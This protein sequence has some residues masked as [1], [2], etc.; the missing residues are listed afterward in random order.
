MAHIW[1]EH[2]ETGN[3]AELPDL[4]YWRAR[5]WA[6]TD[7]PPPEPDLT[8]DPLPHAEPVEELTEPPEPPGVS[9]VQPV[10]AESA[11]E[12]EENDRG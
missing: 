2:A 11:E 8:R 3:R 1:M 5:G 10:T 4:P 9:D 7:G 6:P 12:P